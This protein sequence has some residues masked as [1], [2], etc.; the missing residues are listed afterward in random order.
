MTLLDLYRSVSQLGF[1]DSLGDESSSRFIYATNRALIEVN[2][3]RPRRKQIDINHRVPTNL[4]PAESVCFEKHEEI[5]FKAPGAKS[6]YFE[7]SGEGTVQV[8]FE[9]V[10]DVGDEAEYSTEYMPAL[11]FDSKQFVSQKGFI[12]NSNGAFIDNL[13]QNNTG[14]TK[15]TGNV[16]ITFSGNF[17]YTVRNLALY[18][19]IYSAEETDI[20]PYG[21]KIGYN[22]STTVNDFEKFDSPPVD[23][24]D[25]HLFEGYSIQSDTIY[26]PSDKPGVYT[27][28]YLH[29]VS[30]ISITEEIASNGENVIIDLEEDLAALLPNLIAAYVWLD[31]EAEKS[32]YYYN[33]YLQRAELIKMEQRNLNPVEFKSV[34]GW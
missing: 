26:L 18:D 8:G 25:R 3:L 15:Y 19:R 14:T 33:L 27:I 31:D 4:L 29:K 6:F 13:M 11:T 23:S 5:S 22:I 1:E 17:D 10:T 9:K 24:D 28:N 2:S 30:L 16:I 34:Y 32:Q 20:P 7:V 12:K 21:N